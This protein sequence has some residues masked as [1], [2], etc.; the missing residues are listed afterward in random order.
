MYIDTRFHEQSALTRG[1]GGVG[2]LW[3]KSLP[4]SNVLSIDSDRIFAIQLSVSSSVSLGIVS[5]YLPITDCPLTLYKECLQELENV[6]F[7]LQTDGPVL[8]MGDFNAILASLI[9]IALVDRPGS[10]EPH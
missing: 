3:K 9:V 4:I 6:I 7:S 2:I 10:D 5:V 8:V 1:C